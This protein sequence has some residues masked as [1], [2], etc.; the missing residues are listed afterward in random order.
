MIEEIG[1]DKELKKTKLTREPSVQELP[2]EILEPSVKSQNNKKNNNAIEIEDD[3]ETYYGGEPASKTAKNTQNSF[4]E[5]IETK[6][7][8]KEHAKQPVKEHAKPVQT[9]T[10]QKT[11]SQNLERK[12][13]STR[14]NEEVAPGDSDEYIKVRKTRQVAQDKS[15]VDAKGYLGIYEKRFLLRI[16]GRSLQS[17]PRNLFSSETQD[18]FF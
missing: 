9:Q 15:Y 7:P 3:E 14:M 13:S 17:P 11:S 1:K 5:E 2:Q 12:P 18:F 10:Q 6:Q 8:V 16:S 4:E